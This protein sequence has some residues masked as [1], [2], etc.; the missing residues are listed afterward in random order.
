MSAPIVAEPNGFELPENQL[1]V[2][3]WNILFGFAVLAVGVLFGLEQA[4]N[5]ARI[6]AVKYYPGIHSYYQG[7]TL[8]GV[9]NALVLTTAF[10][11]GF[12]SLTTARGLG[13]ALNGALLQI[14][15]WLLLI[16]SLLAAF[17]MLTDHANVLYTFY[18]PLQAQ[19]T[20]YLGLAMVVISTWVTSANQ[21]VMLRAW[22][23]EH[24]GERIPLMAF[25]SVT[26]Y[27][28][29]DIAS[30]GLAVEVVGLLLPWSLGLIAGSDPL[31]SRTLFWFTGH[32]IVYFW[33]LPIYISWYGLIPKQSGGLLF[34]DTLTRIAFLMFIVLVPVGFH[35]Q[36][37]DPGV[38][39]KIKFAVTIL[40]FGIFFPSL[41]TAFAVM[42]AL[43]IAGRRA[44][45]TG[46]IGWFFRIP[47]S[48]PSV[49]AQVLGMLAFLLG[50]ISGLMNA[51]F[52]M[53]LDIHNTAFIPGHF[54]LTL[55]TA[56]ALSYMGIAYW[57]IPYLFKRKLWMPRLAVVQAFLY[58]GGVLIFSRGM[59][60]GGLH[61]MPRRTAL[62]LST[63]D[64]PA[65]HAAGAM[66]A[67]GGTIMFISAMLFFLVLVMT[68]V[69]GERG[70]REDVPFTATVQAP[71]LSG[72][73]V[74]LDALRY[75]VVASVVL[76]I[77]V[78]GP[79]LYMYLPPHLGIL[80]LRYP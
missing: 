72:W 80:P 19:W 36:F 67:I 16:G 79:F 12:V 31:L 58:F 44:G 54:H 55:G 60:Y 9:L 39:E 27:I 66:A 42:Y 17:A 62:A 7:L 1:A 74:K 46:L 50:G 47:W 56:V 64:Q 48:N 29:W 34:S 49:S 75:F 71:A 69:A 63:Y 73:P 23:R 57:L 35:H 45:G 43:E 78:Y 8:H 6:D 15:F 51:S 30:V 18:P 33:L 10:A 52:S 38:P 26:T 28:M 32:P 3:R 61:G 70:A 14:A 5:Y 20:F 59:M 53:N 2:I 24:P 40:T 65:W 22:R 13:R 4:L 21:L 41:M 76:C 77:L 25:M 37:L 68:I 11:N